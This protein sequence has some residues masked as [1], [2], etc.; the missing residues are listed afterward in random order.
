MLEGRFAQYRPAMSV[1]SH[2]LVQTHGLSKSFP[3]PGCSPRR[4]LAGLSLSISRG[5]V[6]GLL[7]R[8]GS[9]K[10]TALEL[11]SGQ[12]QP[13]EG[14]VV[15]AGHDVAAQRQ[16]ALSHVAA[17]P[18]DGPSLDPAL[19]LIEHLGASESGD[20]AAVMRVLDLWQK[21]GE[22]LGDQP[23]EVQQ[24]V[25]LVQTLFSDRPILLLDEPLA[26]LDPAACLAVCARLR[27]LAD[28][29]T[30]AVLLATNQPA[31]VAALCDRVAVLQQGK[32]LL[33][34]GVGELG[35]IL[36]GDYYRIVLG[37][38]LDA[39]RGAWFDD[40]VLTEQH[41]RSVLSGSIADQAALQGLL[42]RIRDL[43]LSLIS[44]NRV[45]PGPQE[46]LEH[47]MTAPFEVGSGARLSA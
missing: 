2:E 32:K 35:R 31:T 9:G 27:R 26:G 37:S 12:L 23:L 39:R 14:R 13:T 17:Y 19:P 36:G 20:V 18:Y 15:L 30:R 44:V 1:T 7:G 34:A 47:L 4:A 3:R 29:E 16:Q 45:E 43:G 21:R 5:Q 42:A 24:R 22:I 8:L 25:A 41:G 11:I 40:L 6:V 46:V 33:D 10:S 28:A 38:C